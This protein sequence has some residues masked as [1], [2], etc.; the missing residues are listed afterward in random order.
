MNL[1]DKLSYAPGK[2]PAHLTDPE[3]IKKWNELQSKISDMQHGF[4]PDGSKKPEATFTLRTKF[5]KPI[6]EEMDKLPL[7]LDLAM[8]VRDADKIRDCEVH[9]AGEVTQLGPKIPRGL[10]EVLSRSGE[11][12]AIGPGESGRLRACRMADPPR[13]RAHRPGD[14]QSCVERAVRARHRGTPDNF[15]A[16]GEKPTHPELLDYLA[17]RFMDQGWSIKNI[18]REIVLSRDLPYEPPRYNP[19]R[20]KVDPDNK[21]LWRAESSAVWK[22]K[23]SAIRCCSSAANWIS[24][25]A[26]PRRCFASGADMTLDAVRRRPV[27]D[28]ASSMKARASMCRWCAIFFQR[29][30]RR[31]IFRSPARPKGSREVTTVPT[32]ALF[33]MNSKFV[34]ER[35]RQAAGKLLEQSTLTDEQRIGQA[36]AKTLARPPSAEEVQWSLEFLRKAQQ[37]GAAT[38]WERL[39]QAHVCQ[40]R[41]SLSELRTGR[42]EQMN[43]RELLQIPI[44]RVRLHGVRGS[45][46][47]G[48]CDIW[49]VRWR[50][51]APHFPARAKRVIFMF[52]QGGPASTKPS[53]TIRSSRPRARPAA[54]CAPRSSSRGTARAGMTISELFP[55]SGEAR[56]R[57]VPAQRHADRQPG[58]SAGRGPDAT[59]AAFNFMRPSMGAWVVYGL[60]TENQDLPG[61]HHHQ[62]RRLRRIARITARRFCP[63][64]TRARPYQTRTGTI[65]EH[66]QPGHRAPMRKGIS[67]T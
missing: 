62:S 13:Q 67:S 66:R 8:G 11:K 15:G 29:C 5:A 30:T 2:Q 58:A 22:W 37:E 54:S 12:I 28:F 64:R 4:R 1:L 6:Q 41:V 40:R 25:R 59:P 46:G 34:M 24:S 61:F 49:R 31:S 14:G 16:V 56:R 45:G 51:S 35:C 26:S 18:I 50:R 9:I 57:S 43:R 17:V 44:L 10:I 47:G 32:Q 36:F 48:G 19:A 20:R 60:G 52:M 7:P 38:A 27:G 3:Q 33:M 39:Y 63:P 23:P 21:L 55:E 53:T 65:A 42:R